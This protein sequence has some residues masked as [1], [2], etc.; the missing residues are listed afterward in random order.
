MT[1]YT[2]DLVGSQLSTTQSTPLISSALRGG[3][4]HVLVRDRYEAAAAVAQNDRV[5]LAKLR[6]DTIINPLA[7]K[8][9]FDDFGTSVTLDVG[10]TA[11][12][13]ALVAAQDV[14]AAAGSCDFLKS[15]NIDKYFSPLW[16]Q[17]GL[18]ADPGGYI[19][20]FAKFEGANPDAGTLAW[21]IVGQPR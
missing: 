10:S 15:V 6:S 12:E 20:I 11:A 21:Q 9:W 14:A 18:S 13:N 3:Q 1:D 8:I 19:E 2:G 17:L 4:D 5:L 16:E 7:S